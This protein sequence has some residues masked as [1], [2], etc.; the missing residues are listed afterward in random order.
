MD[1]AVFAPIAGAIA[2]LFAYTLV[3]QINQAHPGNEKMRELS[4]VIQEGA[5]AFLRREY[6]FLAIFV[7]VMFVVLGFARE[8]MTS[9][10]FLV[11]AICSASAGFVG[12]RTA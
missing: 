8:W 4:A 10:C 3:R 12:M 9:V 7:V 5:M 11:G 1:L 6:I 2:V